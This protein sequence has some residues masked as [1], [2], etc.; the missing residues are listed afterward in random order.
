ML[1][2]V[3][4]MYDSFSH[5]IF[6]ILCLGSPQGYKVTKTGY[7]S[8]EVPVKVVKGKFLHVCVVISG[9]DKHLI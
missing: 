7:L 6:E 1:I 8:P 5:E 2:L 4:V 3:F 9:S